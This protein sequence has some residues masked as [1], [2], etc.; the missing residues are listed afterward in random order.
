MYKIINVKDSAGNSISISYQEDGIA[1]LSRELEVT[2]NIICIEIQY[3][4]VYL[5]LSAQ[6]DYNG[7]MLQHEM[8]KESTQI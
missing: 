7:I 1:N 3:T 6:Y 5:S 4:P 8:K 2:D